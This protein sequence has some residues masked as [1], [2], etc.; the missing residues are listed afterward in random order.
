MKKTLLFTLLFLLSYHVSAQVIEIPVVVHVVYDPVL[1]P[2]YNISNERI[3]SQLE[4]LNEDYRRLNADTV[5]TPAMFDSLAADAQIEFVLAPGI[6]ADGNGI[7]RVQHSLT[8]LNPSYTWSDTNFN[9]SIDPSAK[10][11][12]ASHSN[13]PLS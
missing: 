3:L 1:T 2:E 6:G 5:N 4:V 9:G 11:C 12:I 7:I 10:N 13:R 8:P